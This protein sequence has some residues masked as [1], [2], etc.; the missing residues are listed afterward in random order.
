MHILYYIT[1]VVY[2]YVFV[3]SLTHLLDHSVSDNLLAILDGL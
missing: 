3:L 1:F 2:M